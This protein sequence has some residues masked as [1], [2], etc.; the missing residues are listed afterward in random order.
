MHSS[1]LPP[2]SSAATWRQQHSKQAS[3]SSTHFKS[4]FPHTAAT[5]MHISK[6]P[7]G[8]DNCTF[9]SPSQKKYTSYSNMHGRYHAVYFRRGAATG[10]PQVGHVGGSPHANLHANHA[11]KSYQTFVFPP[12]Q[13]EDVSRQNVGI[14]GSCPGCWMPDSSGSTSTAH[15]GIDST[16]CTQ[17]VQH[18][19]AF[20]DLC[21]MR[22]K[23]QVH[24]LLPRNKQ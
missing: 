2:F 23:V 1:L 14:R 22:Y 24:L 4:F 16:V 12:F 18:L 7:S 11:A 13:L 17:Q 9:L 8:L 19:P 15:A 21:C 6:P 3:S 5:I 20:P 10:V